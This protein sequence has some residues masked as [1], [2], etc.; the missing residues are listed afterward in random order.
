MAGKKNVL[1]K[2][3][4]HNAAHTVLK[5]FSTKYSHCSPC[6]LTLCAFV[7]P[8]APLRTLWFW[9]LLGLELC[10]Y[11]SLVLGSLAEKCFSRL[12]VY[13]CLSLPIYPIVLLFS[14]DT[15]LA[16]AQTLGNYSTASQTFREESLQVFPDFDYEI[17]VDLILI[18]IWS[19]SQET[20][21]WFGYFALAAP[22][23]YWSFWSGT[24]SFDWNPMT[25][26]CGVLLSQL[27]LT[28][29]D[30]VHPMSI[31]RFRSFVFAVDWILP[32]WWRL[33]Q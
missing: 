28:H 17:W 19:G 5:F 13:R 18:R 33:E 25:H 7:R 14:V 10:W 30:L 12:V 15:D 11:C 21:P 16:S 23:S 24:C 22:P 26:C 29:H 8:D 31:S 2:V 32:Y 4:V 27:L 6:P 20:S 9:K 1:R 3:W